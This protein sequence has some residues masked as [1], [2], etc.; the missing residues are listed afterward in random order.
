MYRAIVYS[1][2]VLTELQVGQG[3]PPV[4]RMLPS[5]KAMDLAEGEL[6]FDTD[7]DNLF[8][9]YGN[10]GISY[11]PNANITSTHTG[12]WDFSNYLNSHWV[13]AF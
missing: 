6:V 7:T 4:L 1:N 2:G 3:T 9:R 12:A 11:L 13:G 10:R 8:I 5:P